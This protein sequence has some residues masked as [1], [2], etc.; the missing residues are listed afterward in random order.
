MKPVIVTGTPGAGKT[1]LARELARKLGLKYIDVKRL[2]RKEGLASGYDK[3]RKCDIVDTGRLSRHLIAMH[4]QD[5]VIDSHL[6]HYMPP[7]EVSACIVASCS[8]RELKNRLKRRRYSA[9][10]IADNLEA[11]AFDICAVEAEELG[12][13]VLR[14][15]TS[16][17]VGFEKLKLYI[18]KKA[19]D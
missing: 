8:L 1:T 19:H 10:K 14:M 5:S 11:E 13:D 3:K 16:K 6:S 4:L 18:Q 9:Q 15:D 17:P 12:H 2:I 7:D